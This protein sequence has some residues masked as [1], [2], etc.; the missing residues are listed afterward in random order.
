[1][2]KKEEKIEKTSPE[3]EELLGAEALPDER[4]EKVLA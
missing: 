1:M 3:A 2:A 4:E